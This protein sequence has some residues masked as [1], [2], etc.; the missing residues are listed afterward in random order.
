MSVDMSIRPFEHLRTYSC[1]MQTH[2]HMRAYMHTCARAYMHAPVPWYGKAQYGATWQAMPCM[3]KCASHTATRNYCR[4]W[5]YDSRDSH[6]ICAG[7]YF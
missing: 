1:G 7:A 3:Q 5:V 2:T 4:S 6:R